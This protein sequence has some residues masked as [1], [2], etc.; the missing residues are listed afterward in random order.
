VDAYDSFERD[1][2]E[3]ERVVFAERRFGAERKPCDVSEGGQ[4]RW[5][6]SPKHL[7]VVRHVA[8]QPLDEISQPF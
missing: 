1:G 7:A 5:R 6:G 3:P 4:L 8:L 2:D